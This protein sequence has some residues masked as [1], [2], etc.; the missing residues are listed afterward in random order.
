MLGNSRLK[1]FT[2][3][4][5]IV[6]KNSLRPGFMD[7]PQSGVNQDTVL[8]N[9]HQPRTPSTTTVLHA[10]HLPR[11]LNL[12]RG[13]SLGFG[14]PKSL[15]PRVRRQ[16][17][18]ALAAGSCSAAAGHCSFSTPHQRPLQSQRTALWMAISTSNRVGHLFTAMEFD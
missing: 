5:L 9:Q 13:P 17:N 15:M 18:S 6:S 1:C 10:L 3:S 11:I 14:D 16:L 12:C 2:I 7:I 8:I 4:Q